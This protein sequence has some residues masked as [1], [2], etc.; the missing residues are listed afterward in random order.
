[1]VRISE[2]WC[3]AAMRHSGGSQN[4]HGSTA[5]S[6]GKRSRAECLH[7]INDTKTGFTGTK[8][9]VRSGATLG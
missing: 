9:T 7:E 2:A 1:M 3:G 5:G 8:R 4:A 6:Q